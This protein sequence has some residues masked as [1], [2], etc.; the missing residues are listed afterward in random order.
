[1]RSLKRIASTV[2]NWQARGAASK[3]QVQ[4]TQ[5]QCN[6][7][8]PQMIHSGGINVLLMDGSV[9]NLS[10]GVDAGVWGSALTPQGGEVVNL[11]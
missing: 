8:L 7:Y 4:P 3:F 9:R 10:P 1:M 2:E 5:A 11:P 6:V